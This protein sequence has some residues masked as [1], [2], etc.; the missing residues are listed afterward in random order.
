MLPSLAMR[1]VAAS[2]TFEFR[3]VAG[4]DAKR[5]LETFG[6]VRFRRVFDQQTVGMLRHAVS[7]VLSEVTE[8]DKRAW[9]SPSRNGGLLVQRVS[10]VNEISEVIASCM[11][12][13]G[14]FPTIGAWMFATS[15]AALAVADGTEG[16]DGIVLVVKDPRNISENR[17]LRWHRDQTFTKHLPINPFVNCGLSLDRSDAMRGGLIV[18]P[19]SHVRTEF[20]CVEESIDYVE[21]QLTVEAQPGDVVIHH[22]ALL[23]RSG[24]HFIEGETRRILYVNV[25]PR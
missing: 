8:A 23:H 20:D 22:C 7:R 4:A 13:A 15:E 6:F 12:E 19:G 11:V 24:P 18:L 3:G 9:F 17:D 2:T 5:S 10:R 21:G 1:N 14:P 25:F 16:S